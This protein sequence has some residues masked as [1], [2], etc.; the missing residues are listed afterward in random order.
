[1]VAGIRSLLVTFKSII[2]CEEMICMAGLSKT[3]L[4]NSPLEAIANLTQELLFSERFLIVN[5]GF[6]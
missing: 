4:C 1:M 3:G 5:V 2:M 6:I